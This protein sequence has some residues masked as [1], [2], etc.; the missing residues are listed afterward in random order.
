MSYLQDYHCIMASS[1][2]IGL[3]IVN[4][5]MSHGNL[6]PLSNFLSYSRLSSF[7]KKFTLAISFIKEPNSYKEVVKHDSWRQAMVVEI[8]ALEQNNT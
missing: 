5:A 1:N 3:A 7:H 2:H 8:T 6:Y 4:Q